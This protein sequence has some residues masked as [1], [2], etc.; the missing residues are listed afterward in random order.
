MAFGNGA[1]SVD[2][3]GKVIYKAIR[4]SE[5]YE[6]VLHYIVGHPKKVISNNTTTDK[7]ECPSELVIQI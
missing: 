6:K 3:P 7:I 1:T 4:V 2:A 5:A